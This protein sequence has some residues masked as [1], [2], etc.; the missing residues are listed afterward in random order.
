MAWASC[1]LVPEDDMGGIQRGHEPHAFVSQ[2]FQVDVLEESLS[3]TEQHRRD[4][5][6]HLSDQPV[7]KILLNGLAPPPMR[8]SIPLA[9]CRA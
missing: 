6:V 1:R 7:A 2:G 9:A 5:D 3:C 4:G 8:T